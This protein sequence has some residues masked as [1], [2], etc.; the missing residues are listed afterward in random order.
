MTDTAAV[1]L[2]NY[3]RELERIGGVDRHNVG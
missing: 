3:Q 2:I 1:N